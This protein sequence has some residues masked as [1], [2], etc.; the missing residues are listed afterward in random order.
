VGE[1]E[2][3][4]WVGVSR[5]VLI[6]TLVAVVI[7]G[8]A[9][10]SGYVFLKHRREAAQRDAA[11]AFATAWKGGTL[12]NL[13]YAGASGT[14]VATRAQKITGGLTP[15]KTDAPSSVTVESIQ[16]RGDVVSARLSVT[17]TLAGA[18]RWTYTSTL[19]LVRSGSA[20]VPRFT[21][22]VIAPKLTPNQ[23][24]DASI[25]QPRRGDITGDGDQV[26]VTERPVVVVGLQRSRMTGVASTVQQ[27]ASVVGVD[28]A[29][30]L[31][32]VKAAGADSLVEVITLRR[33]AY[34]QVRD[35]LRPIP[36]TV[37][38]ERTLALAPTST[39][40]RALLGTVG[41]ATAEI[42]KASK[43]RVTAGETTGLSGL[44][45]AYDEQ[46]AGTAGL[47]VTAKAAGSSST[48]TTN[49]TGTT[50]GPPLFSA[51]ARNG[52]AVRTTLDQTVQRAAEKALTAA[53]KPAALVAIR[54]S[55]G[56]V[57]AVA[58]GGPNAAG[59]DR[60]LLG[61][62]PPGSTF[63]VASTLALLGDG[64]V[65][66]A[67][68][69]ACPAT[70]NVGGR[71]FSNAENEVL[72]A[73]PFHRDFADSCNTA[74]VG[75]STKITQK[76]LAAAARSLGYGQAN[77]LGVEAFTGQVP[78]SG[79]AVA[80]A[81]SMIGQGTV[82]ASPVTVAGTAA[83]VR[84]GRWNPPRLVLKAGEELGAAGAEGGVA[85]P[86]GDVK[87]L[88]SLMREVVTGG[89]A[90]ALRSTPGGDVSGKTGTAEYGND[91]PPR[92]HAW[93]TGFQGDLA[94][95]VVVEDGG[96]GAKSAVPLVKNFLTR[97]AT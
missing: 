32:R 60:A 13:T 18:R 47:T 57:L 41:T 43:G 37:F 28:G 84:A 82:L 75:S 50:A 12:A 76:Q 34:D 92:T 39:F 46:L 40:A 3:L 10:P 94:F 25:V 53:T 69:V 70:V 15:A 54:P 56:A 58:N 44:Q 66:P 19:P 24:L 85:L 42:I 93:F 67:T 7:V 23:V 74:F 68:T 51:P 17:W 27:V 95:A 78:G 87:N 2:A 77:Q 63:K 14:D 16:T 96:F 35:R 31:R 59:Y 11:Q 83:A 65:T 30:L 72:G 26:L 6:F 36:G 52:A 61:R 38:Q 86:A 88:R 5:R 80:H 22:T 90:T 4:P 71:V 97:L 33:D 79:D 49:T 45:R 21:P 1:G 64:A 91:K 81:A 62:Y 9:V 8:A 48:T 89:T 29:A 20:W 73:A 55:T